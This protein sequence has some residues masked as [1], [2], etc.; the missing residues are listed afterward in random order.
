MGFEGSVERQERVGLGSGTDAVGED[1]ALQ[2]LHVFE[3]NT[4]VVDDAVDEEMK[5][6]VDHLFEPPSYDAAG[7][8]PVVSSGRLLLVPVPVLL[9]GSRCHVGEV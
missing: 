9:T 5:L 3:R 8:C 7:S 6:F 2:I 1:V 4:V